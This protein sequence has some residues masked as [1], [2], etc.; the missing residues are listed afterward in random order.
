[1]FFDFNATDGTGTMK[2]ATNSKTA[3]QLL[4]IKPSDLYTMSAEV[5]T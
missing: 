5:L 1:M 2:L 3:E 4:K